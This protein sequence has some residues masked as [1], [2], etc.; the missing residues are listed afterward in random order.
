MNKYRILEKEYKSRT[1]RFFIQRKVF[2]F[3]WIYVYRQSIYKMFPFRLYECSLQEA[4]K[5]IEKFHEEE[6][7]RSACSSTIHS[8]FRYKNFIGVR[9]GNKIIY[10]EDGV[11]IKE[12]IVEE[13]SEEK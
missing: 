8:E 7:D 10:Y 1:K 13:G 9:E 12:E 6:L 4:H 11:K 2:F 5:T 3:F